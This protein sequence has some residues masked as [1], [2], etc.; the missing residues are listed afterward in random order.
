MIEL[1]LWVFGKPAWEMDLESTELR[2][3]LVLKAEELQERLCSLS[4]ILERLEDAGWQ[5]YHDSYSLYLYHPALNT[6]EEARFMLQ[7][8][9]IP[10]ECVELFCLP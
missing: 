2:S 7:E 1:C 4:I 3:S 8:L 6:L 5:R 9:E 10:L